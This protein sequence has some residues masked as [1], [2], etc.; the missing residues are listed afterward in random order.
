[1]TPD[2]VG[3][4]ATH[5]NNALKTNSE[6]YLVINK[7]EAHPNLKITM[8][9][10]IFNAFKPHFNFE[11]FEPKFKFPDNLIYAF[12]TRINTHSPDGLEI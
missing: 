11:V 2:I 8:P 12:G 6:I 1:M 9:D 3:N 5:C 4:Y 7:K 10:E